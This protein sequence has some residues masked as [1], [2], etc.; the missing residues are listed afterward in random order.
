MCPQRRTLR[1]RD[2]AELVSDK[3]RVSKPMLFNHYNSSFLLILK[4]KKIR[5]GDMNG[6]RSWFYVRST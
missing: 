2:I 6:S 5:L 1:P 4:K 3:M